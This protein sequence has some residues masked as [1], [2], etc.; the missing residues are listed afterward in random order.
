[1][2]TDEITKLIRQRDRLCGALLGLIGVDSKE[3]LQTMESLIRITPAPEQDKIA[4]LNAI[5]ALLE[6]FNENT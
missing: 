5:H 6:T 3:E 4:M 2:S 1:M